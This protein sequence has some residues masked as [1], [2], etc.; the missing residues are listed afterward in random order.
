M[1]PEGGDVLREALWSKEA[2]AKSVQEMKD[3]AAAYIQE[4]E[5]KLRDLGYNQLNNGWN[6]NY[7]TTVYVHQI[8]VGGS[9]FP[10]ESYGADVRVFIPTQVKDC[11][12][13]TCYVIDHMRSWVRRPEGQLDECLAASTKFTTTISLD[14][15]RAMR[16]ENFDKFISILE[17][18]RNSRNADFA[19]FCHDGYNLNPNYP[20]CAHTTSFK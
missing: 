20:G 4:L 15:C 14:I 16:R 1:E 12:T 13:I 5:L 18:L 9:R 10:H 19:A 2:D 7:G 3:L 6:G 17:A 8:S 11:T